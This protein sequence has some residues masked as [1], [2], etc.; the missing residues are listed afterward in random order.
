LGALDT[1]KAIDGFARPKGIY[2]SIYI[3]ESDLPVAIQVKQYADRLGVS[4]SKALMALARRGL[5]SEQNNR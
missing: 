5:E 3:A 4:F 1:A 2:K